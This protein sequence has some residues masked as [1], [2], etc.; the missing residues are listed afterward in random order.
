MM[1]HTS[2]A[3]EIPLE[4]HCAI[5]TLHLFT[6]K[7]WTEISECLHVHPDSAHH[8]CKRAKEYASDPNDFRDLFA[9]LQSFDHLGPPE[10]ILEDSEKSLALKSA[11]Q[12]NGLR[13][14]QK[15]FPQIA[16]ELG[17]QAACST[18]E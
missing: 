12:D 2:G 14:Y 9:V 17:I 15:P 11:S 1:G 13:G 10:V 3:A 8:L 4:M 5:L 6:D 7:T 18:I 16:K